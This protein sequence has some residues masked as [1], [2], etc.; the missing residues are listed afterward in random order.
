MLA[1]LLACLLARSL[2]RSLGRSV[3]RSFVRSF[4]RSFFVCLFFVGDELLHLQT[5]ELIRLPCIFFRIINTSVMVSTMASF[6]GAKAISQP[7]K[8]LN[9]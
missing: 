6:R 3:G 9:S 5:H 1:C 8:A 2:A 7:P 4:V